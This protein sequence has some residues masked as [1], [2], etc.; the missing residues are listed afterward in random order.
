MLIKLI[1]VISKGGIPLRLRTTLEKEGKLF[2]TGMIEVVKG[3][4]SIMGSG[5]V[6][7]LEFKDDK[8]IVTE[9][10]KEF[11]VVALVSRAAEH[12]ESLIRIIA[13]EIDNSSIE[14]PG[15]KGDPRMAKQID[16]IMDCFLEEEVD[17]DF[18]EVLAD[19]WEPIQRRLKLQKRFAK[20]LNETDRNM[21]LADREEQKHWSNFDH[22]VNGQLKEAL[23]Y[24]LSGAFDYACAVAIDYEET[25]AK[26][27]AIKTGLL[28]LSMTR[29]TAPTLVVLK[30]IVESLPEND[31]PFIELAKAAV[32]YKDRRI[33][34]QEYQEQFQRAAEQFEFIDDEQHIIQAFLFIEPTI[35][36]LPKFAEK[37]AKYF[38]DK[39]AII[40]TF[41]SAIIERSHIFDKLYS[42]TSYDQFR[43]SLSMWKGKISEILNQISKT[44]KSGSIRRLLGDKGLEARKLG[45]TGS[46]DLQT[47]F[48]L[49]TALTESIILTLNERKELLSEIIRIYQDY[50]RK[51]LLS[52]I[53]LFTSTIDS[54]FQS[55]SVAMAEY[56]QLVKNTEKEEFIKQLTEFM[57][58]V[59]T[60]L[61]DE[62]LKKEIDTSTLF[63]VTNAICPVL[64]MSEV[65]LDEEVQLTHMLL[66]MMHTQS[67]INEQTTNPRGYAT[68]LGNLT[69]TLAALASKLLEGETRIKTLYRCA[70]TQIHV[71]KYFLFHGII[72][73]DDI[74]AAT[75]NIE[76]IV[77][78]MSE[79]LVLP[80]LKAIIALNRI[81][82]PSLLKYDYE[83][84]VISWTLI[85][86]FIKSWRRF[87]N[88]DHYQRAK[89]LLFVSSKALRKYGFTEKAEELLSQ[90]SSTL[91]FDAI[92][93]ESYVLE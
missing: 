39:S 5:E 62:W 90:F 51:L 16:K 58:D 55:L 14:Q 11:T 52:E 50:F 60:V 85:N 13:E 87:G 23:D 54:A 12:L 82:V 25:S 38:E 79:K 61:S 46:L 35:M 17:I 3:L 1:G 7:M 89:R 73:R 15:G 37:M 63:A 36:I 4:S 20:I 77:D 48:A 91:K 57:R 31:D 8:L 18:R 2:L 92:E 34:T 49:H 66:R 21:L 28:A 43:T 9:S 32:W 78:V 33:S 6:R 53:P 29:T 45:I 40:A 76:Q 64:T 65:I 70:K 10:E 22:K 93:A 71:H 69:T 86:L 88:D 26:M 84:A 67:T 41:I 59:I 68:T 47:Y 83:A 75:F 80:L 81:T 72:C 56:L 19:N 44:L 24:A 27:L 30:S 42:I 74:I